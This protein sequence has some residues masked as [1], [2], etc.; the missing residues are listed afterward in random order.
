MALNRSADCAAEQGLTFSDRERDAVLCL[1]IVGAQLLY[2]ALT[3]P[4]RVPKQTS[5]GMRAGDL[6]PTENWADRR[7]NCFHGMCIVGH[8]G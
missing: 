5:L 8:A 4:Y 3:A 7:Q 2:L 1:P 6:A